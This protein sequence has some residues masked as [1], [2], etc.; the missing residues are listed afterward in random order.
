MAE[1]LALTAVHDSN[2]GEVLTEI[3]AAAR[4]SDGDESLVNLQRDI[5]SNQKLRET[6]KYEYGVFQVRDGQLAHAKDDFMQVMVRWKVTPE[7]LQEK[8]AE[9]LNSTG[10]GRQEV[11]TRKDVMA[12]K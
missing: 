10:T 3:E 11:F 1:A 12:D 7:D 2:F 8:T 9:C 6:M 4:I 5:Y